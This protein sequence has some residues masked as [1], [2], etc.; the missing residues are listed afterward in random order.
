MP[1]RTNK[2]PNLV[3]IHALLVSQISIYFYSI[4]NEHP[5]VYLGGSFETIPL[6]GAFSEDADNRPL[7]ASEAV[8]KLFEASEGRRSLIC[9]L[10]L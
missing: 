8:Y 3:K 7:V 5:V 9:S 6:G 4:R 1:T 10:D 2:T